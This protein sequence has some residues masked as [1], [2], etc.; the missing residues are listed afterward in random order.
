MQFDRDING[1]FGALFEQVR[2]LL[3]SYPQI[4]EHKQA[5]QTTYKDNGKSICMMRSNND[6]LTL[7]WAK[8]SRMTTKFPQ[9]KGNQ[10]I[11]RH[12]YLK[13]NVEFDALLL[14]NMV[15][16]SLVLNIEDSELKRMQNQLGSINKNK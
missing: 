14:R 11:V 16:E 9:L 12:L 13:S 1:S 6:A 4:S 7:S 3:L 10:K 2:A 5:H 15:E 8:G